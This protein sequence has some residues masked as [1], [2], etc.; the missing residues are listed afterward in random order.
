MVQI[1]KTK[2][3]NIS[4]AL[5]IIVLLLV[6]SA[7][8]IN[9]LLG[10]TKS[11]YFKS[12]SKKL[13]FEATPDLSLQ[14]Y[15]YDANNVGQIGNHESS[16]YYDKNGVYKDAK[17]I[18]QDISIG[19]KDSKQKD[20]WK[21]SENN[22]TKYPTYYFGDSVI[23]QIKIPVSEEGYY[24]L[25]FTVDFL[26]GTDTKDDHNE[27]YEKDINKHG[28]NEKGLNTYAYAHPE[29]DYFEDS[30]F[31]QSY[32]YCMGCEVL[33]ADDGFTFGD[34]TKPL[35]MANR[36]SQYNTKKKYHEEKIYYA[37]KGTHS[38]YQWKTLTPTRAETVK[39]S[40]KA[41]DDDVKNGYVIWAWDFTGIKGQHNYRISLTGI[42]VKKVM[43]TDGTTDYRSNVDPYFMFPQT[44]FTNNQLYLDHTEYSAKYPNAPY[45]RGSNTPGKTAYSDGRGTFI[46]EATE[47]SLGLRAESL[48]HSVKVT[49]HPTGNIKEVAVMTPRNEENNPVSL[50]IPVKNIK[51]DTTYKVTFDFSIARQGNTDVANSLLN[52]AGY[53]TLFAGVENNTPSKT[54]GKNLYDYASFEQI[55]PSTTSDTP[56]RSYLY[57]TNNLEGGTDTYKNTNGVGISNA[58]HTSRRYQIIYSDKIWS[59]RSLTGNQSGDFSLT[60]YDY[61]TR[62]NMAQSAGL[63]NFPNYTTINENGTVNDTFCSQ[64]KDTDATDRNGKKL[65]MTATTCRNWYNAVQHVEQN[66][67]Q[68]INWITFYNTTFSFNIGE[69]KNK[70]FLGAADE[71]G[72]IQNLYWVWQIDAL[73]HSGWYNIRID[74]VRIEEVVKYS[75]EISSN[76]VTI[77][78]TKIS[79]DHMKYYADGKDY[80]SPN[81]F[82]NYRG[83]NGTGQNC[84]PRGYDLYNFF[85]TGNIYAPVIDARKF[86][87]A[88]REGAGENDYKIYL[89]GWAVCEGGIN[90]Y[91][92][93]VD[94][95]KT[96][97]DM[98]FTGTHVMADRSFTDGNGS[99]VTVSGWAY[100]EYGIE[101]K[102]KQQSIYSLATSNFVEFDASDG[103][104]CNFSGGTRGKLCADLTPYK[105]QPDLDI[106]IAAVP[107]ANVNLRCEILR[108]MNYHSSNY[109]ASQVESISSDIESSAG[110]IEM[111][112]DNRLL[113]ITSAT[114]GNGAAGSWKKDGN[115]FYY[116][117]NNWHV[118]YYPTSYRGVMT[119]LNAISA[120][121]RYDNIA[122]MASNLP[123]K[124]TLTIKG[125]IAC[126]YGVYDYAYSIDGG[127]TWK[128]ITSGG[129][130]YANN[131]YEVKTTEDAKGN[132][133][134]D[135]AAEI[136]AIKDGTATTYE[137]FLYQWVTRSFGNEGNYFGGSKGKFDTDETALK[138][139][140]SAY[141]G[142][143]LDVIVAAKP[144]RMGSKSDKND[145]YLPIAKV[146]NVGVYGNDGTFYSRI[147]G[148]IIDGDSSAIHQTVVWDSEYS[149][150]DRKDYFN[151]ADKWN[152]GFNSSAAYTI[153]EPQNV[154][155]LNARY[156]NNEI[157]KIKSGGRITIDGYVMCKGGVQ[158]YKFSLD[159]GI[160]W[161][162]INDTAL[163]IQSSHAMENFSKFSDNLLSA[164]TDGI[165]GDFCCTRTTDGKSENTYASSNSTVRENYYNHAL[166]FNLPALPNGAIR[167][168]LVVAESTRGKLIPVLR[169]KIQCEYANGISQYGYQYTSDKSD[170]STIQAGWQSEFNQ[171]WDFA[172]TPSSTLGISNTFNRITIPVTEA[173]E[174]QLR[175]T[176]TL[177]NG[178]SETV[179]QEHYLYNNTKDSPNENGNDEHRKAYI[180]LSTTKKHYLV[181]EKIGLTFSCKFL[182]A[183]SETEGGFG[184]VT[185]AII[186]DDWF[187]EEGRQY[188]LYSQRF[189]PDP[190]GSKASTISIDDIT[191]AADNTHE[192]SGVYSNLGMPKWALDLKAGKYSIVLIHRQ[193]YYVN[194]KKEQVSY[195]LADILKTEDLRQRYVLAEVPIYIHDKDETVEFSVVHDEGEYTY[196]SDISKQF[197]SVGENKNANADH[198]YTLTDPFSNTD[199]RVINATVNVTDNDVKRGYIVLDANYSNLLSINEHTK[200]QCE[201]EYGTN[202]GDPT[203]T[204]EMHTH[205]QCISRDANNGSLFTKQKLGDTLY[206]FTD[207]DD[208]PHGGF[209]YNVKMSLDENALT[210]K[211]DQDT[212]DV[213]FAK[214]EQ[215]YGNN[216]L[217]N[218]VTASGEHTVSYGSILNPPITKGAMK[219]IPANSTSFSDPY[220]GSYLSVPKTYFNV[221]EPI[222]VDYKTVGVTASNVYVYITSAQECNSKKYGDLYIK[223]AQVTNNTAGTLK[224]TAS[225]YNLGNDVYTN[226][227]NHNVELWRNNFVELNKLRSL[228]AGEY[229]IWLI[230]NGGSFD[231]FNMQKQGWNLVTEPISIKVVD[232]EA[233]DLSMTYWSD[234]TYPNQTDNTTALTLNKV[235]YEQ[236]ED[237]PFRIS[238][239]Y[240]HVWV[241][242]LKSDDFKGYIVDDISSVAGFESYLNK[243]GTYAR[244][245]EWGSSKHANDLSGGVLKTVDGG[246]PLEPGQYKVVYLFGQCLQG[247]W[248][249]DAFPNAH[250]GQAQKIMA[251]IDITIVPKNTLQ[252]YSASY[253]RNDGS[254]GNIPLDIESPS[255][256]DLLT[257]KTTLNG[258]TFTVNTTPTTKNVTI[259][260]PNDV[261]TSVVNNV[262][263]TI[264]TLPGTYSLNTYS[265]GKDNY[266]STFFSAN[267]GSGTAAIKLPVTQTG[268]YNLNFSG[269]LNSPIAHH[270]FNRGTTI[271]EK[272]TVTLNYIGAYLSVPKTVYIKGEDIPISYYTKG[273]LAATSPV[274]ESGN[275]PW[276]GI[277]P[278][279]ATSDPSDFDTLDKDVNNPN[280]VSNKRNY[281]AANREGIEYIPTKDL[282]AGKYYQIYLRDNSANVFH[283]GYWWE[284]DM[285]DPITIYIADSATPVTNPQINYDFF[286]VP[287][288]TNSSSRPD[289]RATGTVTLN[290]NVFYQGENISVGINFEKG[291]GLAT[292]RLALCPVGEGNSDWVTFMFTNTNNTTYKLKTSGLASKGDEQTS[293]T[294]G[295]ITD[296][297]T[298]LWILQF[299]L[300]IRPQPFP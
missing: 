104:N 158:R 60:N 26:F 50:Q 144:H 52:N 122:T 214:A 261:D 64:I 187:N 90:K 250:G 238:G 91:V 134:V 206:T 46:T 87:V 100:A 124:T 135:E 262:A 168:L 136:A 108:I 137:K 159:G 300:K 107:V 32:Q 24:T 28:Y 147:H 194:S 96:W 288:V 176:H 172:P 217:M 66:G 219:F 39:L 239:K 223:Q 140:L 38:V 234:R 92:Y 180:T 13:D 249:G 160:T 215:G 218:T 27:P 196:F 283:P 226:P 128:D 89:D 271:W 245:A 200:E 30:V 266:S 44:S 297:F 75:S 277:L 209:K 103:A 85:A 15:L 148:V 221:G 184:T 179:T 93:S 166:E 4:L 115:S 236:G 237:I 183:A 35:N 54:L 2:K 34:S 279:D 205:N 82:A 121:I 225:S 248:R 105:N 111:T 284:Y 175:F 81:V 243:N 254:V 222:T 22:V 113:A 274:K 161:T 145:I 233:P 61:V 43:N 70:E 153:F 41:T 72:F 119:H 295:S 56:F 202:W 230:N 139:D 228:C 120:P 11:E 287:Y 45:Y 1:K 265:S 191:R 260:V 109:Y 131:D 190:K 171:D 296:V 125:Y 33:N 289:G 79:T 49:T 211:F 141:V 98:T 67:Q 195:T 97:H 12:L 62:Y 16:T 198:I 17:N 3:Y 36:I 37:D 169:M 281:V 143:V 155:A 220:N 40:F 227:N 252:K 63:E 83:W 182:N 186:S 162:V 73:E 189:A 7:M 130:V 193:P 286:E 31:T 192:N 129:V 231:P 251:I 55:F 74:N 102:T 117:E 94:G 19:M 84:N 112:V 78:D 53:N 88:P 69:D 299:Y 292:Y 152:F 267:L 204:D 77:A 278:Y 116:N 163:N 257:T 207:L 20:Y 99:K 76:G 150:I 101:Q 118:D 208:I 86:S 264:K 270:G 132:V 58:H 68:G 174:H 273:S 23:Y 106:I 110:K 164:D 8:L 181:G 255:V 177:D 65:E 123:I 71:K 10:V 263:L 142:Q 42:D 241:T 298:Q 21:Y 126:Y 247:A 253:V 291:A 178:P 9:A 240:E 29:N 216:V 151:F 242:V 213:I 149:P 285:V 173:G 290:K 246:V 276:I 258:S 201:A 48:F 5:K 224:F 18:L 157:N 282:E 14:Y 95:G 188:T 80:A 51:Y 6:L 269:Y 154:N 294:S 272:Q 185:A 146:D 25:D 138:I 235:V 280:G 133:I 199:T 203:N 256:K 47:N 197:T 259:N 244:Y 156:I 229:K 127:K 167:D 114:N 293:T 165:N 59:N 275:L 57:A 268:E 212:I 210:R 170:L 232:P